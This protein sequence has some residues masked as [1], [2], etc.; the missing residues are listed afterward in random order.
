MAQSVPRRA[1][2]E[3]LEHEITELVAGQRHV[4]PRPGGPHALAG[5]ALG[6]EIGPPFRRGRGGPGGWVILDEPELHLGGD[7]LVPDLAGWRVERAPSLRSAAFDVAPD[8]VCEVLSPS[9]ARWDRL[10][11]SESY[12]LHG[13]RWLWLVDPETEVLEAYS[14]HEGR[15]LRLGG[16]S[17]DDVA[18][19]PPFDAIE[20]ELTPLWVREG[21]AAPTP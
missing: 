16:W 8:W 2:I 5:S 3:D 6:E 9:S 4:A 15:W 10:I 13:V 12:A 18:R 19:I 11:K 7:V 17:G 14:L 21:G 1:A 20:I